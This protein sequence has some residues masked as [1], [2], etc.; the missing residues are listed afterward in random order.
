ME[1]VL[2]ILQSRTN[3]SR[4]PG[5]ALLPIANMPSAVLAAKRAAN[6][7][8]AVVL[9]TSDQASDEIL[10]RTAT[11]AGIKV[12]RG[13][14][15]NVRARFLAAA[16]DLEDDHIIIRLTADNM[17]PDGGLLTETLKRFGESKL[18]YLNSEQIWQQPPH[19]LI[20]EIFYLGA[21]REAAAKVDTPH[22]REHVTTALREVPVA[23]TPAKIFTPE[24]SAL[25][26]T[27]DTYEDFQRMSQL[28]MDIPNP[29]TI[30]W[31]DLLKRLREMPAIDEQTGER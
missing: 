27:M 19:G 7:G 20:C 4:L 21:L 3:S 26:V 28:F 31:R 5:K 17:L 11:D 15:D 9:A 29:E 10:S 24:E 25:R 14:R 2:A 1:S 6:Q 13:D 23:L 22:N 8:H 30:S 16:K 18:P 12:F